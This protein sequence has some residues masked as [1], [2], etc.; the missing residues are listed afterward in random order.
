MARRMRPQTGFNLFGGTHVEPDASAD[1][2]PTRRI[3]AL[4]VSGGVDAHRSD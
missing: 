2:A 4:G 1:E 3:N